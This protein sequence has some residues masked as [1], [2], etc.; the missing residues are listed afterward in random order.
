MLMNITD[1]PLIREQLGLSQEDLAPLIGVSY[2]T[3]NRWENGATIPSKLVWA[4]LK[5]FCKKMIA[6]GSLKVPYKFINVG[7]NARTTEG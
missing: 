5:A 1:Y 2:A 7:W 4:N 3:V 6:E